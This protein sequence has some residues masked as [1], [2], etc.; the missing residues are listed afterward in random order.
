METFNDNYDD[1]NSESSFDD[2]WIDDYLNDDNNSNDIYDIS[3][4]NYS[5]K[6]YFIYVDKDPGT[7][8]TINSNVIKTIKNTY[9]KY[10]EYSRIISKKVLIDLIKEY[11]IYE[12]NKYKLINILKYQNLLKANDL[13]YFIMNI[14]KCYTD[15]SFNYLTIYKKIDDIILDSSALKIF[16]P[17]TSIYFIFIKSVEKQ[18]VYVV[19]SL[20]IPYVTNKNERKTRVNIKY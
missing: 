11:S 15:N 3:V 19:P 1:V 5:L 8:A 7:L 20:K 6:A 16:L 14:D 2:S 13:E 10:N 18:P 12:N 4:N 17:L 9:I